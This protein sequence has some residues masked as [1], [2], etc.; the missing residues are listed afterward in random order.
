MAP[1][2]AAVLGAAAIGLAAYGGATGWPVWSIAPLAA[3]M[4]VNRAN[5]RTT[6][7]ERSEALSHIALRAVVAFP[8]M[9]IVAA[10]VFFAAR[11]IAGAL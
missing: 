4:A 10:A 8:V 9:V 5:M 6:Y 2:F 11:G 3:L 1:V 7:A